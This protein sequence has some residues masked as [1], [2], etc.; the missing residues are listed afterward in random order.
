[1]IENWVG[2]SESLRTT[3]IMGFAFP[4]DQHRARCLEWC[5][6][7]RTWT[8]KDHR[9][10]FTGESR[11][12]LWRNDSCRRDASGTHWQPLDSGKLR[13]YVVDPFVLPFLRGATNSVFQ[14]HS[15]RPHVARLTL[16]SLIEFDILL[17]QINS[18]DLNLIE[19]LSSL[20]G[21]GMN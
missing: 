2:S 19:Y 14:Q 7:H 5:H 21:R 3:V 8:I 17:W 10:L 6:R 4:T 16:N 1:M 11:F 13:H 15:V 12:C 9:L 20:I 18:P